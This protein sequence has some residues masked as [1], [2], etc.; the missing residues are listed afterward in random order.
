VTD[1]P[2][3]PAPGNELRRDPITG[4]WVVIAAGRAARPGSFPRRAHA[5]HDAEGCPFCAGNEDQ[6]PPE[7]EADRAP[8]LPAD[9]PGWTVRVVPNKYAALSPG[10]AEPVDGRVP[11][12]GAHEVIIHGPDHRTAITELDL[13]TLQTVIRTWRSRLARWR[14]EPLG[15]VTII[16][17]EGPEAGASLE[18][19]HSQLFAT[20]FRPD[21]TEAELAR[22]T[23]GD[24]AACAL[25]Q[26]ERKAGDRVVADDGGL[27]AVCPWASAM[28]FEGLI[29]PEDHLPAFEDGDDDTDRTLAVALRAHL[30]RIATVVEGEPALNLVLHSAPPGVD[31][32]HWH[33]HVLPRLTIL[34]GFELGTGAYINV[35]DPDVAADRLRTAG[36]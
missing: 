13:V 29:V 21:L 1:S 16:V 32:F 7:V 35:V 6:T 22:L 30:G 14:R 24:C 3:P 11:A 17:N 18:H 8:G 27:L 20:A 19:A 33:L 25:V 12:A 2:A 15:S 34:G 26:I 4:R 28:P 31:D 23:A 36:A 9:S 10:P 5:R